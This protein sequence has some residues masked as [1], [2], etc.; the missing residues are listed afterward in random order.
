MCS[1][2]KNILF[3]G[4]LFSALVHAQ[5]GAIR[6][7]AYD[8][9]GRLI[10]NAEQIHQDRENG[11]LQ[12]GGY[13]PQIAQETAEQRQRELAAKNVPKL[14]NTTAVLPNALSE[15]NIYRCKKGRADVYADDENKQKFTNCVLLRR[16]RADESSESLTQSVPNI[17]DPTLIV[18]PAVKALPL[19]NDAVSAQD[20]NVLDQG[21]VN[22][23]CS[24]AILYQGSTY[25]FNDSEPC[26]IPDAIFKS[27]HP[28]E[29]ESSYYLRDSA[30]VSS[31]PVDASSHFGQ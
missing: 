29:A 19:P 24:G 14:G 22:S 20:G 6:P 18:Q 30:P 5:T 8:K 2:L 15:R 27:R 23:P 17:P 3:V 16:G 7:P 13:N 25:I 28:I 31:L 1:L 11:I 4:L 10:T 12:R 21:K 9:N 26:P